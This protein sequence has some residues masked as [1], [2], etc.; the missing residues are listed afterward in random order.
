MTSKLSAE[1]A[2]T[3]LDETFGRDRNR[4]VI[5]LMQADR[6][7]ITLQAGEQHL[8]P[9]GYISGPTQMS[10]VDSAAYFAV[11]TRTGLMPMAVTS[12]LSINFL[13]PCI[14]EVVVADAKMIKIGKALAVIEVDVR[15]KGADKPSSHAVVTYAIPRED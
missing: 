6:A 15:I 3:Y 12:N 14:G 1:A 4:Y 2:N 11:M 5:T 13:R 9:G 7:V 8:R 10:M